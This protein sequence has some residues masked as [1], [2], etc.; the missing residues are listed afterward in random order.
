MSVMRQQLMAKEEALRSV[1]LHSFFLHNSL[2]F[3]ILRNLEA[4]TL[5]Q[6][7]SPYWREWILFAKPI[8]WTCLGSGEM[9]LSKKL[10]IARRY[11]PTTFTRF[12]LLDVLLPPFL[13]TCAYGFATWT[14]KL[15][16]YVTESH[17]VNDGWIQAG[18]YCPRA[19]LVNIVTD[20]FPSMNKSNRPSSCPL[21]G[22]VTMSSN[23]FGGYFEFLAFM[24]FDL[25]GYRQSLWRFYNHRYVLYPRDAL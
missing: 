17:W 5:S 1:S 9:M 8:S 2:T 19:G 20:A 13:L 24:S 7:G 11:I 21:K 18:I 4:R 10:W 22:L 15:S 6:P 14:L 16:W 23:K 3:G 12:F 25:P